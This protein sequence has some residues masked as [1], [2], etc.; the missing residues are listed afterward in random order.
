MSMLLEDRVRALCTEHMVTPDKIGHDHK[1]LRLTF[2]RLPN[3]SF[4]IALAVECLVPAECVSVDHVNLGEG[5][6]TCGY[7]GGTEFTVEVTL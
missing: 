3:L 2:D 1:T 4:L 6:E 5:C 7:G